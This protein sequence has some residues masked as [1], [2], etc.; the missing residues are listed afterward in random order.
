MLKFLH[1]GGSILSVNQ[2]MHSGYSSRYALSEKRNIEKRQPMN[3][4]MFKTLEISSY[5]PLMGKL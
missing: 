2:H 1:K 3:L 5:I 4:L